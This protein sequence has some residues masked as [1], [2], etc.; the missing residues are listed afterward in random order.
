MM[1]LDERL[2]QLRRAPPFFTLGVPAISA[3]HFITA[4]QLHDLRPEHV[5][6]AVGA[7]VLSFWSDASRKL[8][9]GGLPFL[10]WV[11]VYDSMRWYADA[12]RS[13]I[14]HVKEPYDFDLRFFGI[15]GRTPNEWL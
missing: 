3:A 1:T 15:G 13:P 11:A 10:L 7:I 14:I 6:A 8:A 5:L 12:I 4:H 9:R 2:S